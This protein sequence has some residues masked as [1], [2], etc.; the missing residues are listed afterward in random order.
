MMHIACGA[1]AAYLPY[2]GAMLHSLLS[3]NRDVGI[4]IHFMHDERLAAADLAA[5]DTLVQSMGANLRPHCIDARQLEGFPVSWRF[6]KE[7][8]YRALLPGLLPE[9]PRILYLDADTLILRPLRELWETPLGDNVA[10]AVANPLYDFMDAGFMAGLG[11][12]PEAYFNS[13]M[14]LLNLDRWRSE[15]V[16]AAIRQFVIER[17]AEQN[18]PDQNALNCVLNGRCVLVPAIWNAQSIYYDLDA[19]QLGLSADQFTEVRR[20]PAVVHFVAPYKPLEFLCKHPFRPHFFRHLR[21]T[22][23]RDAPIVDATPLNRALRLLP[24][25]FM[26]LWLRKLRLLRARLRGSPGSARG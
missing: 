10:A 26:W 8:W 13:G 16:T 4:T 1:N 6:G 23:W 18:W 24:Q 12:R 22:P 17:G 19:A 7:A 9:V 15:N 3:H 5:L 2:V 14:L 25:P 21:E 11:V 20:N